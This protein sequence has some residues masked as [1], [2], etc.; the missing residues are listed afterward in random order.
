MADG[1]GRH[2]RSGRAVNFLHQD[3]TVGE[4]AGGAIG[5]R[6]SGRRVDDVNLL[7]TVITCDRPAPKEFVG[8]SVVLRDMH[9]ACRINELF[10]RSGGLAIYGLR[11]KAPDGHNDDGRE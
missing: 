11:D 6:S 10:L 7:S 4:L 5:G 8:G 2:F 1:S 3:R 9:V